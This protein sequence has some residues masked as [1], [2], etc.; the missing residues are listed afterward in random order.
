MLDISPQ[1]D[2]SF[3]GQYFLWILFEQLAGIKPP[4]WNENKIQ[5]IRNPPI[6]TY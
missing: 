3:Y 2:W 4:A 6:Y 5:P 1:L